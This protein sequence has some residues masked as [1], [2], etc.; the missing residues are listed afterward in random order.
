[1]YLLISQRKDSKFHIFDNLKS[2]IKSLN[3]IA[4]LKNPLCNHNESFR[5]HKTFLSC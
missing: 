3:T 2:K 5:L 4:T 1:M